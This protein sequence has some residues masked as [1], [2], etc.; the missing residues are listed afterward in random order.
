M[1]AGLVALTGQFVFVAYGTYSLWSWDIMEP[2]AYFLTSAGSIY[3]TAQF[4]RFQ[5]DY[6]N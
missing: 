6:S 3:L 1:V 2:M 4:F 5:D